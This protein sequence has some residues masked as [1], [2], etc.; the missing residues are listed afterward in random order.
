[1]DI[2]DFQ[3][4]R[5]VDQDETTSM[6]SSDLEWDLFEKAAT[7]TITFEGDGV[8]FPYRFNM[9]VNLRYD[10]GCITWIL[11]D[12]ADSAGFPC[13]V[14]Q[15]DKIFL[16]FEYDIVDSPV[17]YKRATM[18]EKFFIPSPPRYCKVYYCL[19]S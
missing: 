9:E 17:F 13:K 2:R 8:V 6:K 19:V 16:G 5:L 14:L 3:I 18:V 15:P 7:T 12:Q 10:V 1:M 4:E 11:V